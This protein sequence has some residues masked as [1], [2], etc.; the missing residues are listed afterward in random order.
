V[1]QRIWLACAA[2]ILSAL[3]WGAATRLVYVPLVIAG[4]E[5]ASAWLRPDVRA[6]GAAVTIVARALVA[7]GCW[8]AVGLLVFR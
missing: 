6:T 7:G 4:T 5:V 1:K 3:V 2:G 8:A